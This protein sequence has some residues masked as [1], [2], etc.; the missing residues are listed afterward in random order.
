MIV[1]CMYVLV[2]KSRRLTC[3]LYCLQMQ[4]DVLSASCSFNIRLHLQADVK[5]TESTQ[6][7]QTSV[8]TIM[9]KP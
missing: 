5:T 2:G 3:T 9:L 1:S 6:R 8:E 4:A 7:V